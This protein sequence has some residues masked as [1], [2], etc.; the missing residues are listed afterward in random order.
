MEFHYY[1]IIQDFIGVLMAFVGIRM[2]LLSI[3]M[4]SSGRKS[5]SAILLTI[6][7]ALII[8]SGVNLLMNKF[9]LKPWIISIILVIL[10]FIITRIASNIKEK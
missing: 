2:L 5:K 6:N 3:K 7:Y 4:I 9:G 1:Y 10:S 8:I